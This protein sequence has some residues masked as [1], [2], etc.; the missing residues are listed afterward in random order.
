VN[1]L[2]EQSG[3]ARRLGGATVIPFMSTRVVMSDTGAEVKK[4]KRVAM[5]THSYYESDSRVMRYA[6]SLAERGDIVEVAALR[7]DPR[8]P[9][10]EVINGVGVHRIQDRSTKGQSS[11]QAFL[12]PLLRF[13][14]TSSLWVTWRHARRR[15]HLVHVHNIPDFLVFAAWLPR[16][17]GAKIILDIH[18]IVPELYC[19]KFGVAERSP[20]VRGLKLAEKLSAAFANHVILA[21]HLWLEPYTA[22]SARKNKCCAFIN[23][24]DARVFQPRPS[25]KPDRKPVILFPGGL[26]KHQGLDIA[27]RAFGRVRREFPDAEFHIYG[28][29][30]AKPQLVSLA[31]TLGLR[32]CVQFH[33]PLGIRDIARVMAGADLGVV[34]KRADSFGNRA[35]STKIMEFMSVGVPVV[36]SNTEVDRFY[37]DDSVVKFFESGDPESMAAA[38]LDVLSNDDLRQGLTERSAEYAKRHSW[39]NSKAGYLNLVDSLAS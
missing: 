24:V 33:D 7:R 12:L 14:I 9:R 20:L 28:D 21:N 35:Y 13:L 30:G 4:P 34:P 17:T 25:R 2:P 1:G 18:D 16:L 38:M 11:Q 15:Y 10:R 37:F 39:E 27:I 26:Q 36:V 6:E 3:S 31:E 23:N 19:S 32:E 5:I 29:G 22:R 8:Q